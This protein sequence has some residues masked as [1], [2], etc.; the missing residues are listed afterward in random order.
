M[1]QVLDA[2]FGADL[3]NW[4]EG[5][6][7]KY[8]FGGTHSFRI[9]R[10]GGWTSYEAENLLRRYGILVYGRV[11]K[12]DYVGFSVAVAQANYAEYLL[13]RAGVPVITKLFNPQNEQFRAQLAP[14]L[15]PGGGGRR[16][17]LIG[18]AVNVLAPFAGATVGDHN[19]DLPTEKRAKP[20]SRKR[21]PSKR[22]RGL[23]H[24]AI[25]EFLS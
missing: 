22:K 4:A 18:K 20:A 8:T 6:W 24:R 9:E 5:L 3:I 1:S 21:R 14:S 12:E 25:R 7:A 19:H 23:V 10:D 13:L 15:P 2:L 11:V 17:T 16:P